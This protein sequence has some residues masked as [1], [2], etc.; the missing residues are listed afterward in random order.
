MLC[1][2]FEPL[3]GPE[4]D[5]GRDE[6]PVDQLFSTPTLAN[7]E[8]KAVCVIITMSPFELAASFDQYLYDG[9]QVGCL[10]AGDCRERERPFI[11][12]RR[13]RPAVQ[14]FERVRGR[15]LFQ[16]R[17]IVQERQRVA[18][19]QFGPSLRRAAEQWNL[20]VKHRFFQVNGLTRMISLAMITTR[21][22]TNTAE[23]PSTLS[24]CLPY[25]G[26]PPLGTF[27][28]SRSSA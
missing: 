1:Q 17:V 10:V 24:W 11:W 7:M 22:A 8:A 14:Q 18:Q 19:G 25:F 12:A 2:Q 23:P 20:A 6:E 26:L 5:Q 28:C 13:F 3:A 16:V 27:A 21:P 9:A 4:L 15:L